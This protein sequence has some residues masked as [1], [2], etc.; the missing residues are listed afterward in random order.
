VPQV[1][2]GG[3][4]RIGSICRADAAGACRWAGAGRWVRWW[5]SWWHRAAEPADA[6]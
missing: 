5:L 2:A 4:A 3:D 1:L 6:V